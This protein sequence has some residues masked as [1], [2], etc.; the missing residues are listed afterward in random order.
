MRFLISI[1]RRPRGRL[2]EH[3]TTNLRVG[4][5]NRSGRAS[6]IND[7]GLFS[8][9]E[10]SLCPRCVRNRD[11]A[12]LAFVSHRMWLWWRRRVQIMLVVDRLK[13]RVKVGCE[14]TITEV[15]RF[16]VE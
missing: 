15:G 10:Q 12:R 4:R 11:G 7:L 8:D 1:R 6:E 5:S 13:H 14:K 9:F 2:L 3:Q 16:A